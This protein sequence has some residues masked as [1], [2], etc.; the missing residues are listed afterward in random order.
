MT[1]M[2]SLC[3]QTTAAILATSQGI[4]KA[5]FSYEPLVTIS[6]ILMLKSIHPLLSLNV[7]VSLVNMYLLLKILLCLYTLVFSVYSYASYNQ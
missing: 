7:I 5:L 4:C 6:C 1:L 2:S 3:K